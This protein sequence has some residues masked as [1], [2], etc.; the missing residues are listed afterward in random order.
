MHATSSRVPITKSLI[1]IFDSSL[2]ETLRPAGVGGVIRGHGGDLLSRNGLHRTCWL[3]F[4]CW[5]SY[6]LLVGFT[7]LFKLS[8]HKGIQQ[9]QLAVQKNLEI[10]ICYLIIWKR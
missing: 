8:S 6:L 3:V 7:E 10:T 4:L 1:L 5:L 2:L 9:M